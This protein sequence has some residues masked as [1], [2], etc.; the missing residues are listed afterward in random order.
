MKKQRDIA[1]FAGNGRDILINH[2][3]RGII[4]G[5]V[6]TNQ[7]QLRVW[8]CVLNYSE[9][10]DNSHWIFPNVKTRYL[11]DKR[12]IL[13]NGAVFFKIQT[14]LFLRDNFLFGSQR[15]DCR[16]KNFYFAAW[17][18]SVHE[19]AVTENN[20]MIRRDGGKK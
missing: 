4:L 15:V 12:A 5:G 11:R 20:S 8:V 3:R 7:D 14:G 18:V 19:I 16:R 2:R 1:G 9:R 17:Q 6:E 10:L 13:G